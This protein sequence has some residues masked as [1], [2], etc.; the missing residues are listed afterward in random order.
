[1]DFYET[2]AFEENAR[3]LQQ[4]DI[5]YPVPFVGFP[6]TDAT[7]IPPNAQEPTTVDLTETTEELHPETQLLTSVGISRGMV[8]N[9]A[10]DLSNHPGRGKPILI[11]RVL[12]AQERVKDLDSD[13]T[14]KKRVGA[15]KT[16]A[17]PGRSPSVFYLPEQQGD[18]FHMPRCVVD[19]LEARSFPPSQFDALSALIRARLSQA[20]L[21][22]LQER[23]A[24]CFG[25]FGAPD[26][27]FYDEE[28]QFEAERVANKQAQSSQSS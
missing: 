14:V 10:C 13:N 4:R 2:S 26:E 8:L 17:N 6:L 19:L 12:P 21:Q 5:L 16:L 24:Y 22:S 27:L 28:W 9:Q 11:A 23:L 1:M 3:K 25:R 7:I 18:D 15:I 20:A